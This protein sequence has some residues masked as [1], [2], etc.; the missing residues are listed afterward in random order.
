M[1]ALIE[2]NTW[3]G[4]EEYYRHMGEP[5][6]LAPPLCAWYNCGNQTDILKLISYLLKKKVNKSKVELHVADHKT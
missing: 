1:K 4:I 6:G 5:R 3:S 2:K